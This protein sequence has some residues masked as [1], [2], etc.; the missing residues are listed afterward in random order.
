MTGQLLC[1][2]L[3]ARAHRLEFPSSIEPSAFPWGSGTEG[4]PCQ[5][6]IS[7]EMEKVLGTMNA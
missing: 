3:L 5:D 2:Q 6:G 1:P 4:S 7:M